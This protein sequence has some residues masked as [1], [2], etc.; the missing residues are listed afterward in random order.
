MEARVKLKSSDVNALLLQLEEM[1]TRFD[2]EVNVLVVDDYENTFKVIL[3]N[4]DR[5]NL[6][7]VRRDL[8]VIKAKQGRLKKRNV[9]EI[10][11]DYGINFVF[12][13]RGGMKTK[14]YKSLDE[15]FRS[16]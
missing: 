14:V 13:R 10:E 6:S 1:L 3:F 12:I 4:I 2:I 5:E 16:A 9:E 7:A 8:E 15:F 11:I